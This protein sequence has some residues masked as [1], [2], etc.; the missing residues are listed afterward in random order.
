MFSPF[1]GQIELKSRNQRV[2]P[3]WYLKAVASVAEAATVCATSSNF[4]PIEKDDWR[5]RWRSFHLRALVAPQGDQGRA[6]WQLQ[7]VME[8]WR[9]WQR[10]RFQVQVDLKRRCRWRAVS[11]ERC[12]RFHLLGTSRADQKLAKTR[13]IKTRVSSIIP[14]FAIWK[15]CLAGVMRRETCNSKSSAAR[16]MICTADGC[17]E[18]R[19]RP[20]K[21]EEQSEGQTDGKGEEG[22]GRGD[23]RYRIWDQLAYQ[24][25]I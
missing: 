16:G 1:T 14:K 19:W 2:G 13:L 3:H 15:R 20:E 17:V 9:L 12:L 11:M 7:E 24:V 4:W 10:N 25:S 22:E 8:L 6:S 23:H 21:T 18:A 5:Q